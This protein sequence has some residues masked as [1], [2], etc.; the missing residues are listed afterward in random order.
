MA[1]RQVSIATKTAYGL[2]TGLLSVKNFLFH[3]FFI[4]YFGQVLGVDQ[5]YILIATTLAL[6]VDAFSDPIMG[7][8]SDNYRSEKWGRRHRFM[9]WSIIPTAICLSLLF[10]PPDGLS[11]NA[12]FAWMLFFLLAVRLGLTVF[13]GP[14]YSLGA[15]LSS[16]YNERT[17]IISFRELFN[18]LFNLSVFFFGVKYFLKSRE[19]YENGLLYADG[20]GH[21]AVT[22]A[23]IGAIGALIAIFG[24]RHKIPEL[25]RRDF[26]PRSSW[27]ETFTEFRKAANLKSFRTACLGYGALLILY[28]IGAALSPF[29]GAYLWKLS[30]EQIAK[31]GL[32]PILSILPAVWLAAYLSR[33]MDKKPTVVLFSVIYG[34]LGILPY[35]LYLM[36]ALP[37]TGSAELFNILVALTAL[38]F[39]SLTGAIIV[40]N[41]MLAD[42]A[43]EMELTNGRRQEGVLFAAFT[44]AQKLTFA[45]GAL[46]AQ[47]ALIFI[48]FPQQ[49]APSQVGDQYINGLAKASLIFAIV[50]IL[51]AFFFYARYPLTRTRLLDIQD[52]L[53]R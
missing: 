8:I 44:F 12:L 23:I 27:K 10:M 34:I 22:F 15:E 21:L 25:N 2:G 5:W 14:Y 1:E 49:M 35:A 43:D 46:F 47:L 42:V 4:F 26:G 3:F 31:I 51:F 38:G 29:V 20:Y 53:K 9:L 16:D 39:G 40:S 17:S 19:G 48:D 28:G 11:Q 45:A 7:Q 13:G 6:I 18:S 24:T 32:S 52:K 41:S 37:P 30:A 33:K 50:F 36:D